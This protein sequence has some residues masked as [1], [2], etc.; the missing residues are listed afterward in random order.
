MKF[1]IFKKDTRGEGSMGK[2]IMVV[3]TIVIALALTPVVVDAVDSAADNVS[4]AAATMVDLVP[5]FYIIGVLLTTLVWVV[6]EARK[7]GG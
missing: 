5:L 4:G 3:L 2:I 1:K 6:Y 7:A